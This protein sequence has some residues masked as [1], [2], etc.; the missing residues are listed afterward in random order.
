MSPREP[1][2]VGADHDVGAAGEEAGAGA[3]PVQRFLDRGGANV[4]AAGSPGEIVCVQMI[5]A[6]ATICQAAAATSQSRTCRTRAV[7]SP[8]WALTT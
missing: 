3:E 8:S 2:L 7:G 5:A 4:Q 6:A 1:R